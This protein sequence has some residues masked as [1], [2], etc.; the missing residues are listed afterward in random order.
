VVAEGDEAVGASLDA[1]QMLVLEQIV[2]SVFGEA[3]EGAAE[4]Y[5]ERLEQDW[6][7]APHGTL[8]ARFEALKAAWSETGRA[9]SG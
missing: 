7:L 1:H 2:N 8:V 5:L 6:G 4:P 9:T 3:V